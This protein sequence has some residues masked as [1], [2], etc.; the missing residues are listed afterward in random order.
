[1]A[2]LAAI[3]AQVVIPPGVTFVFALA[4]MYDAP[5]YCTISLTAYASSL[6]MRPPTDAL[7]LPGQLAFVRLAALARLV[8]DDARNAPVAPPVFV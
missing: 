3:N 5:L 2:P 1:M 6:S 8:V 7:L 4:A